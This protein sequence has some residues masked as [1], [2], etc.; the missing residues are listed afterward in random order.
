VTAFEA[1]DE[2]PVPDELAPATV[3]VYLVAKARPVIVALEALPSTVAVMLR[4][5]DV[6]V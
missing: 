6:T 5:F 1:A 4:G 3:K 2:G